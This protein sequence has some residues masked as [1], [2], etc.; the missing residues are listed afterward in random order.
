MPIYEYQ[1]ETETGEKKVV[2]RRVKMKDFTTQIV[3]EDGGKTYIASNIIAR[4]PAM[5]NNWNRWDDGDL[6]PINH[7]PLGPGW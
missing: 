6:P 1:Y 3:V 5:I 7:P 4:T 2:E